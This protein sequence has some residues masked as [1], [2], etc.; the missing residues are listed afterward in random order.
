MS[1]TFE[2]NRIGFKCIDMAAIEARN[3]LIEYGMRTNISAYI[4]YVTVR[5]KMLKNFQGKPVMIQSACLQNPFGLVLV[6]DSNRKTKTINGDVVHCTAQKCEMGISWF[7]VE[8][9]KMWRS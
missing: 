6:V 3:S 7:L 8:L 4:N 1:K 2:W 9:L 5:H